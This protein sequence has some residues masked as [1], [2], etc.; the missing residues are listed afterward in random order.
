MNSGILGL[1]LGTALLP[2]DKLFQSRPR[3]DVNF[4]KL[5]AAN[6]KSCFRSPPNQNKADGWH[7]RLSAPLHSGRATRS[8]ISYQAVAW[9]T[10][11]AGVSI[12]FFEKW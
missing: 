1:Q 6:R 9:L 8:I 10:V 2:Y 12:V 4:Y 5:Q 7:D 3:A 11:G